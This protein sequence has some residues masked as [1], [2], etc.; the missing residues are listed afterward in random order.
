MFRKILVALD[1][2]DNA[3]QVYEHALC[4]AKTNNANLMLLHVLS[5][6]EDGSP[7]PPP[8]SYWN[9]S[10]Q[11]SA[12]TWE[13]YQKQW[14]TYKNEG[15]KILQSYAAEANTAGIDTEFRQILGN[16]GSV[17]CDLARSWEA[18]LII[19]GR[20]GRSGLTEFFLGS[21]SNYVLHHAPCSTL[22]VHTA[23]ANK[24]TPVSEAAASA[25]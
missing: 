1:Q 10:P 25:K 9:Y 16:P 22:T 17:I 18:D 3:Q 11:L 23:I 12:Q 24:E 13:F 7:Y 20:R 5:H 8:F 14:E 4:L 15:L 21:V 19:V 6:E 2:S